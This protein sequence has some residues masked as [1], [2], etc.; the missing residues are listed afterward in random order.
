METCSFQ[1]PPQLGAIAT[2][3][4]P[5]GLEMRQVGFEAAGS[6]AEDIGRK[7]PRHVAHDLSAV[8]SSLGN[9]L[10]RDALANQSQDRR[11]GCFAPQISFILHALGI[12]QERRVDDGH[13]D[14][15]SDKVHGF[16]HGIQEGGAGI[17]HEVP[18]VGDLDGTRQSPSNRFTIPAA[19]I[20]RCDDDIRMLRQ[21]GLDGAALTIRQESHDAA[22]LEIADN[23]AIAL[24]ALVRPVINADNRRPL[25]GRRRPA[26]DDPQQSV[27]ADG[28]HEAMCKTLAWSAAERQSEL[29]NNAFEPTCPSGVS[30]ADS[31]LEPLGENAGSASLHDTPEPAHGHA[32]THAPARSRQVGKGPLIPAMKPARRLAARWTNR[33]NRR[34]PSE[35]DQ[36]IALVEHIINYKP[37]WDESSRMQKSWHERGLRRDPSVK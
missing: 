8:A 13:T 9:L 16:A 21:P 12:G 6:G 20:T 10:D 14:R 29:M 19:A 33:R 4:V 36:G 24:P 37:W 2:A 23:G 1:T 7:T 15:G 3:S 26:P 25:Q 5:F 35:N 27:L 34:P 17:F 30:R 22:A 28:Q 18:P 32:D 11:I 31:L